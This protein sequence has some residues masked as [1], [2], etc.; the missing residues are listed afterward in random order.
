ML[1]IAPPPPSAPLSLSTF[2]HCS[3]LLSLRAACH[4]PGP[5]AHL[6]LHYP[7]CHTP[8]L[9]VSPLVICHSPVQ[10][11]TPITTQPSK[12][13]PLT[14]PGLH[15]GS[16]LTVPSPLYFSRLIYFILFFFFFFFLL[17]LLIPKSHKCS[18]NQ[19][20]SRSPHWLLYT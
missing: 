1:T 12:C 7:A 11:R 4:A 18:T 3:G 2:S 15:Y 6:W 10:A 13:A 16:P 14:H 5:L 8:E 17:A 9:P 20:N 19:L